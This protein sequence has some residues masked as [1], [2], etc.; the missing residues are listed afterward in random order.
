MDVVAAPTCHRELICQTEILTA[1]QITAAAR[2]T[3]MRCS[4]YCGK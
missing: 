1:E 2:T 3:R 4:R